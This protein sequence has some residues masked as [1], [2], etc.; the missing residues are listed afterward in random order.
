MTGSATDVS[1]GRICI[2]F[3]DY[4]GVMWFLDKVTMSARGIVELMQISKDTLDNI[5]DQ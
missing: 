1:N 3:S 4:K 2:A 5:Y